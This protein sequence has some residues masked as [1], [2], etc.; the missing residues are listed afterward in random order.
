MLGASLIYN[1][2]CKLLKVMF[3]VNGGF[4][5]VSIFLNYLTENLTQTKSS[6]Y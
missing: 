5:V 6:S 4:S 1:V 2:I 3:T